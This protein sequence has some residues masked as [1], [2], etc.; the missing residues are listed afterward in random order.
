MRG[1]ILQAA[2]IRNPFT[3][4]ERSFAPKEKLFGSIQAN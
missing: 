1:A 3:Q 2:G 4:A